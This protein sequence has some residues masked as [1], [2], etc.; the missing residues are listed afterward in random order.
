MIQPNLLIIPGL[1]P[2]EIMIGAVIIIML[3]GAQKLPEL[4]KAI[5]R[6]TGE[7]QKGKTESEQE[8]RNVNSDLAQ[9]REK[10]DK[11]AK[12]LGIDPTNKTDEEL[13]TEIRKAM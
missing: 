6:S 4:A 2:T 10:L 13:R 12:E 1:G 3:F 11:I 9:D 5:G 7:F 8:L